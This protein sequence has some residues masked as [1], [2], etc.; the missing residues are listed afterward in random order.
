MIPSSTVFIWMAIHFL[1]LGEVFPSFSH[2]YISDD[3]KLAF[4]SMHHLLSNVDD[5]T[6]LIFAVWV[7]V[8]GQKTKEAA[9]I[10]GMLL[11]DAPLRFVI[12]LLI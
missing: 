3:K 10:S 8:I 6:C 5:Y 1:W 7:M 2:L 9:T 4:Y 12:E 11:P